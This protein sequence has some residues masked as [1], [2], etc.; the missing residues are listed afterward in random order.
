MRTQQKD[1]AFIYEP[2]SHL[3]TGIRA[4]EKRL[5]QI[6]MNLLS[7]AVKFTEK[8]G[9]NLKVGYHNGKIRF[10]VED[11]GIGIAPDDFEK[12]FLPFQQMGYQNSQTEGT[13]LGLSITKKLVG[14]M[15]GQLHVESTPGHGSTF[16]FAL[17]LL[18]VSEL[19]KSKET[20]QPVIIG[21][22]NIPPSKPLLKEGTTPETDSPLSQKGENLTI[23]V[24]DDKWE[25]RSVLVNLLTPLG[26]EVT[27][28]G[29][30][31]EGLDKTRKKRPDLIITDLVM[32]G[33]DGFELIRKIRNLCEFK[34]LPIIASSA[35]V[36]EFGPQK[37]AFRVDMDL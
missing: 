9:V 33:I 25:N 22:E 14:M 31:K 15:D 28:A 24:I 30:G 2:L 7:N 4:D 29:D 23:L 36:F 20:E 13:G 17:D 35:S 11:T 18:D 6:L 19:V 34:Y 37:S 12:I 32:P 21:Y 3:P 1:I 26:F 10:Q 8:G 27:E 16:W 5:R